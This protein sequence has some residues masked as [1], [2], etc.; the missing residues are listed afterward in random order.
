MIKSFKELDNNLLIE[1]C[2]HYEQNHDFDALK[3]KFP[4]L[5][6]ITLYSALHSTGL[7]DQELYN[8]LCQE[9][10][11]D[12]KIIFISDTHYGS[13]Y[14]NMRY[15]YEVFNYAAA[16][17]IHIIFHG[18]DILAA[19]VNQRRRFSHLKQAN[20]FIREYPHDSS[21]TTHA[22]F[23]NH[24]YISIDRN[25][26]VRDILSS[27]SDIKTLG[28]KKAYIKWNGNVISLQHE[29][30]KYKLNIPINA[31]YLSFKGHSHF[32]HIRER[33]G[34]KCE[35]IYIPAMCDAP[36]TSVVKN[37]VKRSDVVMKPGFLTAEI[38]DD[39]IIVSDYSFNQHGVMKEH[40]FQKVLKRKD[41]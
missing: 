36:I 40:E 11:T 14:E 17:G 24:D 13:I 39:R 33:K 27:R 38:D 4:F 7:Y 31:E 21:I 10:I 35:R 5:D 41:N 20:Y 34:T 2:T 6:H 30:E 22:L 15:T 32:Y 19:N 26:E 23:G 25:P 8:C 3:E 9:S 18:G 37:Q 28:F 12:K 29:I 1:I 16:N